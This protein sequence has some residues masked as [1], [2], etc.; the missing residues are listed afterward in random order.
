MGENKQ[1]ERSKQWI[2]DALFELMRHQP[3]AEI[4]VKDITE[5][6]GVARLTFYRNFESKDAIIQ[7]KLQSLFDEYLNALSEKKSDTLEDAL[8]VCYE[9]WRSEGIYTELITKNHLEMLLGPFFSS[10]LNAMLKAFHIEERLTAAQRSFLVGGLYFSM[11]DWV[12][13]TRHLTAREMAEQVLAF[14]KL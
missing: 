13:D 7:R 2:T 5:K 3:Y 4:T 8:T 6:A 1:S 10:S 12:K 14:I 11:L 9:Y